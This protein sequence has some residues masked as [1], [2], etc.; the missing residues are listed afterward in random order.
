MSEVNK[1]IHY[2]EVFEKE[3]QRLNENQKLAVATIEGPVLVI[4]GPGTGKT[5]IIATRIGQMLASTDAQI[6]PHNILCLTY[7]EAGTIA[8]RKRLLKIIGTDAHRITI[9]TFHAFCNTVIQQNIEYFGRR[10][11]E[12]VSEL[13]RFAVLEEMINELE[14]LHPL[15]RLKGEVF[16]EAGRLQNLFNTMKQE[17][18]SVEL[19]EAEADVYLKGLPLRE[20]YIYKR[21]TKDKK[22]GDIKENDIAIEK[23]KMELLKSAARLFPVYKSKMEKLGRY[24]YQD[25]ILWVI[26]AFR[27]HENLLRNYQERYQYILV[28]EFQDTNG[29][30]NEIL[31]LLTGYWEIPNIFCVGDDDQGIYEFQ[32]ARI[33]NVREFIDRYGNNLQTIVLRQNYRSTQAILDAAKAVIDNNV[34]RLAAINEALEKNLV[35]ALPERKKIT[36]LPEVIEYANDMQEAAG[37]TRQVLALQ[38]QGVPLHEIAILYHRHAHAATLIELFEKKGIPYEVNRSVNILELVEVQQ[39]IDILNYL[40]VELRKPYTNDALLFE[41]MHSRWFNLQPADIA[42]LSYFINNEKKPKPWLLLMQQEKFLADLPLQHPDAI[43]RFRKVIDHWLGEAKNLTLPMLFE[44]IINESGYLKWVL[45]SNDKAWNLQVLHTFFSF[46]KNEAAR[47]SSL[48][49]TAFLNMLEQMRTHK[50]TLEVEKTVTAGDGVLFSTCHSAKG[51]EFQHV[52]LINCTDK[53]WEKAVSGANKYVLPDTLTLTSEENKLESL[54]RLFYVGMTRACEGLHISYATQTDN[55]KQKVAS[56]FVTEAGLPPK[57][58]LIEEAVMTTTL[59]DLLKTPPVPIAAQIEKALVEK[60]LQ[61]F[62]LS[63]SSLNA[64]LDCPVRFYYE[65]IIRIPRAANDS[66]AFGSAVHYALQRLFE[67]MKNNNDIFPQQQEMVN[68]FMAYM[69]K[70]KLSFTEKQFN[71]RMELGKQLLPAYYDYYINKWNKAVVLEYFIQDI[72]MEG[73]P[74]KGK[75]DKIEFTGKAVNV[76]DYKTGS[77]ANAKRSKKLNPPDEKDPLGGDYWRQL[78]FY[79]IMLDNLKSKNWNMHQGIIDFIEEDEK[80]KQFHQ[81][82]L[83][84]DAE[85]VNIVKEQIRQTYAAIMDHRFYT[86][87]GKEDCKW[88]A[89]VNNHYAPADI[90]DAVDDN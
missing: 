62:A 42:T 10:N 35:A 63:P 7:T 37:I 12:P 17:D 38:E 18:W 67:K 21:N 24:D 61:H 49:L 77:L 16:Y 72:E 43:L 90:P 29:A 78:V 74:L 14:P 70:N 71:N 88:C 80:N 79:K 34:L 13:E 76:V 15:R 3:W 58:V 87:C 39:L 5:Q 47:H 23:E 82:P 75:L 55:G 41:I 46:V 64:Y 9:E 20:E 33:R 57:T 27:E 28:D 69:L 40:E 89:F 53:G 44:K 4:A 1:R 81:F 25:M 66:M 59:G 73:I 83:Q 36:T 54:R 56:Q 86:G 19:I 45:E 11:L 60:R 68:D 84:V 2:H 31:H 65:N 6:Q 85:A 22:K 26:A 32:G 8:M 48:S 51:L 30:Q 50:L 52:F